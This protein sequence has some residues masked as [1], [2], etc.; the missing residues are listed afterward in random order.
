MKTCTTCGAEGSWLKADC[1]P[2]RAAARPR[3]NRIDPSL[4][5]IRGKI[6]AAKRAFDWDGVQ[7]LMRDEVKIRTAKRALQRRRALRRAA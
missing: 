4:T 1:W 3:T 2:C 5:A 6:R 7:L